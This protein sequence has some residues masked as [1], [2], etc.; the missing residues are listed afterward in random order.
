M[1]WHAQSGMFWCV[2]GSEMVDLNQPSQ[3]LED[4]YL[5]AKFKSEIADKRRWGG[6]CGSTATAAI[7]ACCTGVH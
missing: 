6:W 2:L 1:R 7:L 4:P 5:L 3:L